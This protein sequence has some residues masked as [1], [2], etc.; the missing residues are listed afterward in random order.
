MV[1]KFSRTVCAL[2]LLMGC[3]FALTA[4]FSPPESAPER[5]ALKH[6]QTNF[7]NLSAAGS[8]PCTCGTFS[9]FILGDTTPWQVTASGNRT[10]TG[11]PGTITWSLVPDGTVVPG[12][13]A[14][15]AGA[16]DLNS[17]LSTTFPGGVTGE[18]LIEQAFNRWDELS[19]LSVVRETND[20][21]RALNTSTFD[22][23]LGVRGDIRIG[24]QVLDGPNGTLAFNFFPNA[25]A[26]MVIDTS[27]GN[28]FGG[29]FGSNRAFRNT[30]MHE[31]GHA[32]GLSHVESTTDALLLEPTINLSFDGPQL[33][34]VRAVQ[35]VFGDAFEETN[36]G[37][38][39]ETVSTATDLGIVAPGG[40]IAIGKDADVPTQAISPTATDF[41]SISGG[42]D[43]DVYAFTVA[44]SSSVDCAVTP[45]GGVFSQGSTPGAIASFDANS[46]VDLAL[47]IID[48]DGQS[49]L[50]S[51]DQFGLGA[52]ETLSS[53][54]LEPGTYYAQIT[55]VQDTIQLYA[56]EINSAV[57][58]TSALKGDVDLNGV[59][60]FLDINAF[61]GILGSGTFQVEAD[62]NC[63]EAVNFLDI[64]PFIAILAGEQ[65]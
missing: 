12:G 63:D 51:S 13:T 23:V 6:A 7:C 36:D 35:F 31:V 42:N 34:E 53:V 65:P 21:G 59:V 2:A 62:A 37:L 47:T 19:G 28:F 44:T 18:E 40:T 26:D 22:G 16:S 29:S 54:L 48:S 33:D 56:L 55:G 1:Y 15:A 14:G 9:N 61:I 60:N 49:L 5:P 30:I 50:A 20:D 27:E 38:G 10:G 43:V 8:T 52:A 24:G 11:I 57:E 46:R 3:H 64:A 41:V 17:F 39:N 45:L 32:I 4:N 25:G 58:N